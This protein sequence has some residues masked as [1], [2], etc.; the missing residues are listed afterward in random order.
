[1]KKKLFLLFCIFLQFNC[2]SQ[3]IACETFKN[4][5][6][7]Q[8]DDIG[9]YCKVIR[10]SKN[11]IEVFDADELNI[12][13]SNYYTITWKDECSYILKFDFS[14]MPW[15][16]DNQETNDHGGIL[17][18][19]SKV[20]NNCFYLTVTWPYLEKNPMK[21]VRKICTCEKI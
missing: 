10:D 2:F 11:Q 4:G 12:S 20:E 8:A 19:M 16:E 17:C 13:R 1:M 3:Q 6:F 9:F 15:D 7:C 14:K 18:E 5:E 21:S